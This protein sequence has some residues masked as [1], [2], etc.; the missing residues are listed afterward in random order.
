MAE[1][2]QLVA[3]LHD[4]AACRPAHFSTPSWHCSPSIPGAALFC[5]DPTH[6]PSTH[7]GH[8]WCNPLFG[9]NFCS[10]WNRIVPPMRT[11][12]CWLIGGC[13][14]N[15]SHSMGIHR[16]HSSTTQQ[17]HECRYRSPHISTNH[18]CNRPR[19]R[20]RTN[21]PDV[22]GPALVLASATQSC[23]SSW[24]PA[25]LFP[26]HG[27]KRALVRNPRVLEPGLSQSPPRPYT[28]RRMTARHPSSYI[29]TV[30]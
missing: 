20:L 3:N 27:P 10:C 24:M 17:Q 7:C 6:V 9:S 25:S 30:L 15:Q 4:Q 12:N 5:C 11:S 8:H 2:I 23:L 13:C 19:F 1:S 28:D 14:T 26:D 22:P 29:P 16:C 18:P 21:I